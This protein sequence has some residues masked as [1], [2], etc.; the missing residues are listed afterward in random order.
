M[1]T[2]SYSTT[3]SGTKDLKRPYTNL[4]EAGG[5]ENLPP[6]HHPMVNV[7]DDATVKKGTKKVGEHNT[8]SS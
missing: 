7:A 6:N 2:P 1:D 5:E 3:L 8:R 4:H